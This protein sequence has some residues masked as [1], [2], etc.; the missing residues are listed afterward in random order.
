MERRKVY[1]HMHLTHHSQPCA[2]QV[3][4]SS[5]TWISASINKICGKFATWSRLKEQNIG[6][7]LTNI[8]EINS[9]FDT[10]VTIMH[11]KSH[12]GYH[13]CVQEHRV[14][15]STQG[16]AILTLIPSWSQYPRTSY[17]GTNGVT[18]DNK[19]AAIY[20]TANLLLT[21]K[22]WV[23]SRGHTVLRVLLESPIIFI[24][25]M[26]HAH[27]HRPHQ[28]RPVQRARSEA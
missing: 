22:A 7:Y 18:P 27:F 21:T 3:I 12:S 4:C 15:T 2:L 17:E 25:P 11:H 28:Q 24:L 16:P 8:S 14:P 1:R 19:S 23:Q 9:L 10:V 20:S 6:N 13:T 26:L 5:P